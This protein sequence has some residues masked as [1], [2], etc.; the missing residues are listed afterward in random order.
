MRKSIPLRVKI[1]LTLPVIEVFLLNSFS[2]FGK[3]EAAYSAEGVLSV[4]HVRTVG[5]FYNFFRREIKFKHQ[6]SNVN[7]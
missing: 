7:K 5:I 3:R 2:F 6:R 1:V 4:Y